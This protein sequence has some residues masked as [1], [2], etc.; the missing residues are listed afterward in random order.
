MSYAVNRGAGRA[1]VAAAAG[2]RA[3]QPMPPAAALPPRA[4]GAFC[5]RAPSQAL[6]LQ[7]RGNRRGGETALSAATLDGGAEASVADRDVE[8]DAAPPPP[9]P[10]GQPQLLLFS[11]QAALQFGD[12]V[13]IVGDAPELGS[14]KLHDALPCTWAPGDVWSCEVALPE[15]S[16]VS[17]KAR[18]VLRRARAQPPVNA[19]RGPGALA[20]PAAVR[21]WCRLGAGRGAPVDA[22][23]TVAVRVVWRRQQRALL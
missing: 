10:R 12:E 17:F 7:S 4:A 16:V 22:P 6:R 2:A 23:A 8:R 3:Q 19:P 20:S 21:V 5:G 15:H 14:W 13:F 11:I 18:A 1:A 9:P